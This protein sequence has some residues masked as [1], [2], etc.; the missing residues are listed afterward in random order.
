M[1]LS[2]LCDQLVVLILTTGFVCL[3]ATAALAFVE[4]HLMM[5]TSIGKRAG[6]GRLDFAE[7]G[8]GGLLARILERH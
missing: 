6:E 1:G 7:V 8:F 3:L 4:W 2:F 5:A